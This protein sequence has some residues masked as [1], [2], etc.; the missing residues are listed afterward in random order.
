MQQT[1]TFFPRV[2]RLLGLAMAPLVAV[3]LLAGT[4]PAWAQNRDMQSL[5]DQVGRMQQDLSDLQRTV[6]RG[7]GA[8]SGG[9]GGA[10]VQPAPADNNQTVSNLYRLNDLERQVAELT[11]RIEEAQYGVQRLN[12]KLDKLSSDLEFRLTRLEQG[13]TSG[14]AA[15]PQTSSSASPATSQAT[16]QGSSQVNDD[17]GPKV[18]GTMPQNATS[19]GASAN[20][21]QS[22][23]LPSGA[24]AQ[25][26]YDV[27]F[28]TLVRQD[29]PT[30]EQQFRGFLTQHGN[31][32]LAGNAQYWLAET[33]YVRGQYEQAAVAFAEGFEKYPKNA[34]APDNLLKL[35]L[36]LSALKRKEDACLA[37]GELGKQYPN[38]AQNIKRRA[39]QERQ[40]LACS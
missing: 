11:G 3:A 38:A 25:E 19:S 34:K 17:R 13:A 36:S 24:S 6:Y 12:D 31:S 16:S 2:T 1:V 32:P 30:A 15:T 22:A 39:L 23:A 40:K 27:A 20:R 35:G 29:F 4:M 5:I 7:G 33:H 10:G 18:L 8:A 28:Q 9:S 21:Q 26:A 37:L 14:A